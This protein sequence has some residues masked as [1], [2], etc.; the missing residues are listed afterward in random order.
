[1]NLSFSEVTDIVRDASRILDLDELTGNIATACA[2]SVMESAEVENKEDF[3]AAFLLA[4]DAAA[5]A[6]LAYQNIANK[7]R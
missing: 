1:M 6:V 3:Q 7:N 5:T 2:V 4:Q